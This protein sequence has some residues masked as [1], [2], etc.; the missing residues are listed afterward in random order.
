MKDENRSYGWRGIDEWRGHASWG[1]G[2]ITITITVY[3][4]GAKVGVKTEDGDEMDGH[5]QLT[6][7]QKI[8]FD[9][10]QRTRRW[11]GLPLDENSIIPSSLLHD[12]SRFS[13]FS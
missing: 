6:L 4:V 7:H 10:L 8:Q 11:M 13:R 1:G 5:E 9:W 12:V 2:T 3:L